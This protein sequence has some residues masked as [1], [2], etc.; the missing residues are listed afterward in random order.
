MRE[1]AR[2]LRGDEDIFNAVITAC[3][4]KWWLALWLVEEMKE[5]SSWPNVTSYK[6]AITACDKGRAWDKAL[7]MLSELRHWD[8]PDMISYGAAISARSAGAKWGLAFW[9]LEEMKEDASWPDLTTYNADIS[10]CERGSAW[11]EALWTL[12]EL[13][14][15]HTADVISYS[16]AISAC[17]ARAKWGLA[18]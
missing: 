15:C 14:H 6:A 12:S 7:C 1:G 8:K 5:E 3:G 10:A 16:A 11:E 2:I 9:L 4:G 13:R 17:G 18:L